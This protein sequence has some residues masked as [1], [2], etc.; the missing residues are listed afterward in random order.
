MAV[1]WTGEWGGGEEG[2]DKTSISGD[3]SIT[4]LASGSDIEEDVCMVVSVTGSGEGHT[5]LKRQIEGL[6]PEVLRRLA[7]LVR[8]MQETD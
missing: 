4:E 5:H 7:Q 8:E 3:I 2:A 6:K 1:A